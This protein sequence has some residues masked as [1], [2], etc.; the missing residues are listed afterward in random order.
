MSGDQ[1]PGGG[2]QLVDPSE[3]G[4]LVPV[5]RAATGRRLSICLINPK[6]EPSYWGFDYALP[7]Y[8]GDRRSSMMTGALP[9]LAGLAGDHDVRLLD[10]NIEPIDFESLGDF[11]LVG[12]TGMI[13]QKQRMREIL[14]E[15]RAR[16]IFSV[17]GGAYASV[18]PEYFAGLCD[19][20]FVGEADTT[21]PAFLADFAADQPIRRSYEQDARTDLSVL[22]KPRYDLLDSSK[23]ASGSLQFSRGCPFE[24]EFCDIIVTFGRIPRTK[25]PEQVIAELEDLRRAGF[26]SV[27]V[28]DDNFIGNKKRARELLVELVKWQ[29]ANNYPVRLSTEASINLADDANLLDL[30]YR[31]NFRYVF[32]GIE[33]PRVESLKET[34][35]FQNTRGDSLED[36]LLRIQNAGLDIYAGFIVGFDHDDKTIFE[37]QYQFIQNTGIQL[38]MVGMLSAI[39]KTPLYAR[40][41]EE[42]RLNLKDPNCN[43]V[44]AQM[45]AEELKR[46]Y[47]ELVTR[48]YTPQAFLERY[49]RAFRLPEYLRRRAEISRKA[50][51]GKLIPTLAYALILL[52]NL[53]RTLVSD[54]SLRSL[55][56]TYVRYFRLNLRYRRDV[57]GFAQFMNRC[58]TH[59]HFFK[60]TREATSGRLRLWNSS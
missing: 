51:E 7:L 30:M 25:T 24:C 5:E 15:L 55:G 13:V 3:H 12:V 33:T 52:V 1:R 20:L 19:V 37:Q 9:H 56:R 11:H 14:L 18:D 48:L 59:W 42:G 50:N 21:W 46:G 32:I 4:V 10:E 49:L 22:P 38:A 60:F 39:P 41:E 45:T 58:V 2:L 31:A 53:L 43:I 57:I 6:F 8:P 26:F 54:G 44:P 36:K 29:E 40:L 47:A 23:F 35:K 27:F 17:V 16:G 34:R 28:V